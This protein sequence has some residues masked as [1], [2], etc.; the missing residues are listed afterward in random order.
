MS[1]SVPA[2]RTP[3]LS[4]SLDHPMEPFTRASAITAA[5]V[6]WMPVNQFPVPFRQRE[7]ILKLIEHLGEHFKK[8]NLLEE[9]FLG[10]KYTRQEL[11]R[12]FTQTLLEYNPVTGL[13]LA[14]GEGMPA[15]PTSMDIKKLVDN[16]DS[17]AEISVQHLVPDYA[18]WF[19]QKKAAAQRQD[20]LGVGGMTML[21]VQPDPKAPPEKLQLSKKAQT[22]PAFA[23]HDLDAMFLKLYSMQAPWLKLSKEVFG[24]T[25]KEEVIYQGIPFI[26]PKL[27]AADF[28]AAT[29]EQLTEWFTVFHACCIESEKDGGLLFAVKQPD[30]D[31]TLQE[32]LQTM[33]DEGM[34]YPL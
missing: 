25:L 7:W 9:T 5:S 2:V 1:E 6:Y 31:E 34:R 28:T 16:P 20:F 17:N 3:R 29:E 13:L 14:P 33:V 22:H 15:T 12:R 30:F 11:N 27:A 23:G 19:L 24:K 26:L 21:W 10:L 18:A 32:L 8:A 4:K